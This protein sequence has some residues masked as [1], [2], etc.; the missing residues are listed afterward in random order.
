MTDDLL[1]EFLSE[2]RELVQSAAGD[3]LALERG[4]ADGQTIDRAFRAVHTLKG[5]AGL[6]DFAPMG[7]TLHAAEDLLD[8]L[9]A[10]RLQSQEAAAGPLLD[11]IAATERWFAAIARTG[12]LPQG[13]QDEAAGLVAALH[14]SLSRQ[15]PPD[16]SAN[17]PHSPPGTPAGGAAAEPAWLPPFLAAHAAAQASLSDG[18][19]AFRYSPAPDCFFLGDDPLATVRAIPDLVA[20]DIAPGAAWPRPFDLSICNLVITGL[21][22]APETTVRDKFRFVADQAVTSP[23]PAATATPT[24]AAPATSPV[25]A[26]TATPTPP[27]PTPTQSMPPCWAP[28]RWPPPRSALTN[29]SARCVSMPPGSMPWLPSWVN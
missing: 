12:I 4:T 3:L 16:A 27:R 8:A 18:G 9:R 25:P 20:L 13:A 22:R 15:M 11:C 5:S 26:A 24:P 28:L 14:A 10:G 29:R 7:N 1:A 17:M 6:F 21:S 2:G 23:V 19:T